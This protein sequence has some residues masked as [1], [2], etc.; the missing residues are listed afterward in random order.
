M[1]LMGELKWSNNTDFLYYISSNNSINTIK[2]WLDDIVIFDML[3]K[4]LQ[5][6]D[7][8]L[9]NNL[10]IKLH[11]GYKGVN[12]LIKSLVRVNILTNSIDDKKDYYISL[13]NL[14]NK[15]Q[16]AKLICEII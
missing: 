12:P 13:H 2:I 11:K 16:T 1:K 6:D 10:K 14:H 9:V 8:D 3:S 15:Y 5:I 4:E 7:K